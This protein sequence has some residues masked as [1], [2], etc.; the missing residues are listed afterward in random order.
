MPRPAEDVH[1]VI[2]NLI[3]LRGIL[4]VLAS[5]ARWEPSKPASRGTEAALGLTTSAQACNLWWLPL[6]V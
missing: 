3:A 5:S 1:S 6:N 2:G 4:T